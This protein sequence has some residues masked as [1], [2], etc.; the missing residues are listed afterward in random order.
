LSQALNY[1][2]QFK[3]ISEEIKPK[4]FKAVYQVTHALVLKASPRIRDRVEA[5][6]I[7]KIL[8]EEKVGFQTT[9]MALIYLCEWYFEEF[10]ISNQMEV[11]ED[12]QPLIDHLLRNAKQQNSYSLLAN[13]K[14]LQAKLAL[15]QINITEARKLLSEAQNIADEHDLQRLAGEISREHDHILE[16]LK[17]WK[18]FK[19]TKTPVSERLKIASVDDVI[20][21][22]QGKLVIEP[23]DP[24]EEQPVILLIF[25]EGDILLLS[26]PFSEKWK[27]DNNLLESFLSALPT[28]NEEFISQGLDRAKFGEDTLLLQSIDSLLICY[29]YQGQ[30][31]TAK[32]K[33][34]FFF[35]S[36]LK[37]TQTLE[38]IKNAVIKN[39]K[40]SPKNNTHIEE[41][42]VKSFMTDSKLF[43]TPF[44]AYE[45]DEPF[46]FASYAHADKLEV[47]PIIDYLNKM[48]I[49]IWYDEGI[50]V[51]ENWKKSI[52]VNLEKCSTFLVFITPQIINSEYVRKEISFALKKRKPFFAVYLK[53][54][55]LPT[56]LEFEIADIQAMMMFL[57]PKSEFYANLKE[58]LNNSLNN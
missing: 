15:F 10:Q 16:D 49:K 7:M 51:S 22:I 37:D 50:P 9:N 58:L 3:Q 25:V 14:L 55:K 42:I 2:E 45:G 5:E 35:E 56:E 39:Q 57:M 31:Y 12:I 24:I 1:F 47:Y 26:Y 18:S 44:K 54:T 41:L 13:A 6:K 19:K 30:T 4:Q 20:D 8:I 52:A 28:F 48:N 46:V 29:L 32:Q 36:L 40:I 34:N 23:L 43:Q 27:Q 33:L 21:R 17:L 38:N 11:L 53:E